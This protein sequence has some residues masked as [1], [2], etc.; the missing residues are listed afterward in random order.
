M[1]KP[2]K[3]AIVSRYFGDW[4]GAELFA[5]RLGVGLLEDPRWEIHVVGLRPGQRSQGFVFHEAGRI[6]PRSGP[7]G[8][9]AFAM[10]AKRYLQKGTFDLVHS[11]EL[12]VEADVVSFGLPRRRWR[13]IV[14]KARSWVS[15]REKLVALLERKTLF[16]PRCRVILC[17]SEL[18]AGELRT[19]Y[20]ELV[21]KIR[22][23]CPGVEFRSF[24]VFPER[25]ELKQKLFG[26]LGWKREDL[27]ALFIGNNF[28]LKGLPQ[29]AEAVARL[30]EKGYP[31]RLCV[32]GRGNPKEAG[33]CL[34]TLQSQRAVWFSGPVSQ[35]L[36]SSY[37]GASDFLLFPSRWEAFGMV[38]LEA[39]ASGLPVVVGPHVGAAK[40]VDPGRNGW[41]L[42]DPESVQELAQCLE[43]L[44]NPLER[45]RM[46]KEARQTAERCDWRF[47]VKELVRIYEECL[48]VT[49]KD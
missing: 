30:R 49:Q 33:S 13:K 18:A 23:L 10:Q 48:G 37:Y 47:R 11:H 17:P 38:V 41:I 6:L 46:G 39:L 9:L 27:V 31:L 24:Q 7:W 35:S 42:E 5:W 36:A 12:G 25:Q 4:G 3:V 44:C 15:P 40:L 1:E 43:R 2:V 8:Q 21:P 32:V 26:P 14:G 19:E 20:P 29:T 16:S 45:E 22:V 34:R 28:R